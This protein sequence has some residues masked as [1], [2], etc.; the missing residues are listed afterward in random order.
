MGPVVIVGAGVSG[1]ATATFLRAE[2]IECIVLESGQS[3][4]GNVR[5][6]RFEGRV[7]DR[8]ATGWLDSEPAMGR[9]IEQLGLTDQIVPASHRSATRW[10]Y[11]AGKMH[12]VPSG[13]MALVRSGLIPWWAKLRLLLEPFIGRSRTEETVH[14]FATRRLGRF[15]ADRLVGP[16][17]AG[18]F[19]A[20]PEQLSLRAAFPKMAAMEK[21]H[22]SL[23]LALRARSKAGDTAGPAGPAGHLQTLKG[24]VGALTEA[25][26]ARLGDALQLQAE[27]TSVRP[28]MGAWEV[29]T[30]TGMLEADAVVLACPAF[31]QAAIVRG[32][33]ADL[34]STLD[35]IPYAPVSVVISAWPAGAFDR[36]PEGFGVLVASGEQV[37]VLGTLFTS[38]VFPGQA[39]QGEHLLR[40]MVGGA[41]DPEA[42]FLPHEQLMERVMASHRT[43]FGNIRAEPTMVQVYRYSRAIPQYTLGHTARVASIRAAQARQPGLFFTGNHMDGIGVKD[44]AAAGERISTA[45]SAQLKSWRPETE[46]DPA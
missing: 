25:M 41:V 2:G 18:I 9:L 28:K 19:A 33:D 1:L 23:F 30:T 11:A 32:L 21:E 12:A 45:V 20:R 14:A 27:V 5:S 4:G 31:A 8:A 34:A 7:L 40:T 36:A 46:E 16:M 37:G 22:R 29:H 38:G 17:V 42:A 24:G 43:F 10:V 35:A 44:C 3:A 6:D 26:A 13:P 39:L 15:F